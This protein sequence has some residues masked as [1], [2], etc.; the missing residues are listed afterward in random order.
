MIELTMPWY[1]LFAVFGAGKSFGE[2]V[3]YVVG[4]FGFTD[5][6][7]VA[8]VLRAPLGSVGGCRAFGGL[9]HA[10][11]VAKIKTPPPP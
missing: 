4:G 9:S 5:S 11:A 1:G 3:D 10:G 7:G 6:V 2:S 8:F